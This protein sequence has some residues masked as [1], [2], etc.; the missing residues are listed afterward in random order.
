MFVAAIT[1]TSTLMSL[2]AP[3]LVIFPSCNARNT[4]ACAFK[5]MSPISSK[6]MVPPFACSN[7]PIRC[8]MAEVKEPFSWPN[9]SLSINS[10]GIAAQFTSTIGPVLRLLFS[11]IHLATSSL[12]TPLSPVISTLA[13]V[14]A[15]FSI[16]SF[17]FLM[18]ILLPTISCTL[19]TLRLSTFVSV[20]NVCL[21]KAL[22]RV[23]NR[24]LRS[25]GLLI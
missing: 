16:V 9:N 11:C 23:I 2:S 5:L 4:F 13:S 21:S 22:R 24:R 8:F 1:L 17:I 20:T 25:G 12:P 6:K 10:P 19:A 7:L 3:T 18:P 14:G 15:T